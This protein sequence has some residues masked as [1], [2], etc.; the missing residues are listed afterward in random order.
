MRLRIRLLF[1]IGC[2]AALAACEPPTDVIQMR[3]VPQ[4]TRD[5]MARV[6]ILPIGM[7]APPNA[8]TVGPVSGFGCGPTSVAASD[9]A[10]DQL[11]L[12]ALRMRAVAVM[13]VV[14]EPSQTGPCFGSFTA[15]ANGTAMAQRGLPAAY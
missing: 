5:A 6:R 10:V 1:G 2:V 11:R 15:I 12:K 3:D 14:I 8:G 13:D 4:V 9:A 7:A